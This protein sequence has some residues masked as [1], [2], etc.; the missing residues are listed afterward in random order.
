MFKIK[1]KRL[2]SSINA[3]SMADIAFLLLIFFLV[4]TTIL[5]DQGL[6]VKLPPYDDT[7]EPVTLDESNVLTVK[8]NAQ[9][10]LLVENQPL[11]INELR[12]QT[13]TF[14]MNPLGLKTMAEKPSKAIVSFQC[15]RSTS[16]ESYL[17]VYNE[18]KAAY[19][20]MRDEWSL[21][22]YGLEFVDLSPDLKKEVARKIPIVI[23]EAEPFDAEGLASAGVAY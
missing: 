18:L 17:A 13:K 6:M 5:S 7:N 4:T 10:A 3:G 20:E 23:S 15:D 8:L 2:D 12:Q 9:N 22:K 21:K 16:Y 11:S 14:I 19:R 1:K